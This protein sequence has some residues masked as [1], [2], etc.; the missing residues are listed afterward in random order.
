MVESW[1]VKRNK[2]AEVL[3]HW[4]LDFARVYRYE[5]GKDE[6]FDQTI[7]VTRWKN[8]DKAVIKDHI[9]NGWAKANPEQA[10]SLDLD[11]LTSHIEWFILG[12][13]KEK[14]A[15]D[16]IQSICTD[17]N[18]AWKD[19]PWRKDIEALGKR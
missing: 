17:I 3:I 7:L 16:I 8:G 13:D 1:R 18:N 5:V 14:L 2:H 19:E 6:T 15:L 10:A 9:Y 12:G 4:V 11:K